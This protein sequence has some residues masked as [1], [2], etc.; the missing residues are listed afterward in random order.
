MAHEQS[1]AEVIVSTMDDAI[2]V[3][4][5]TPAENMSS[6]EEGQSGGA[7]ASAGD[8]STETTAVHAEAV[9][10]SPIEVKG[11][12]FEKMKN[13]PVAVAQPFRIEDHYGHI[14]V[15]RN[16]DAGFDENGEGNIITRHPRG[17]NV[18]SP[19][20]NRMVVPGDDLDEMN[21]TDRQRNLFEVYRIARFLRHVALFNMVLV[22]INGLILPVYLVLFILPLVGYIGTRWYNR[23]ML[24]LYLAYNILEMI[25]GV[26][27]FFV[28]DS[29]AVVVIR[30]LYFM[31]SYTCAR[32]TKQLTSYVMAFEEGD[33]E[34]L[35]ESPI[36]VQV[37]RASLC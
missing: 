30:I 5:A 17:M 11:K 19:S 4:A 9:A 1:G 6:M 26:V 3:Q 21:L 14:A 27:S 7:I 8:G 25:G 31:F 29:L 20:T 23:K 16:Q 35:T 24:T 18:G 13:A 15:D 36:I 34:F 22:L 37:E 28:V 12:N 32:Y 10:A 33:L 2:E